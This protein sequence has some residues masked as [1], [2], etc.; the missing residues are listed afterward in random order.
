M[1][2][3]RVALAALVCLI[4]A[5]FHASAAKVLQVHLIHRHGARRPLT[6]HPHDPSDERIANSP[7]LLYPH[8]YDQL[9]T[10]GSY[11]RSTYIDNESTRIHGLNV[12]DE[13]ETAKAVVSYSSN[14]PRTQLSARAFLSGLLPNSHPP[15]VASLSF[16]EASRDWLLRGYAN[17]P[18][19]AREF[20]RFA[21]SNSDYKAFRKNSSGFVDDLARG[22]HANDANVDDFD[23]IFNIYDRYTIV[24]RDYDPRP[25]GKQ[26]DPLSGDDMARLKR[27]ADWVETRRYHHGA[28]AVNVAGGFLR[29]MVQSLKTASEA[30]DTDFPR[31]VEYSAHY[32]TLLS[33]FASV[34]N[35]GVH[36]GPDDEPA[37]PADTIPDFGAALIVELREEDGGDKSVRFLW[38]AGGDAPG[39]SA[40]AIAVGFSGD[41]KAAKECALRVLEEADSAN[42]MDNRDMFCTVCGDAPMCADARL[43]SARQR[44]WA[45]M[46]GAAALVALVLLGWGARE[47]YLARAKRGIPVAHESVESGWE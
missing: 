6:K 32:P 34:R 13:N 23:D 44:A 7:H 36:F 15:R 8:G 22:L 42:G 14:L 46:A 4:H 20:D 47:L 40:K 31:I 25:D 1:H 29:T 39:Q 17:C 10:L 18:R 43:C 30:G 28:R 9:R 3:S 38:Y 33:F 12:A 24:G 19:L 37:F 5:A 11:I 2:S 41:C 16:H 35:N 27:L 45:G 26:V 21:E